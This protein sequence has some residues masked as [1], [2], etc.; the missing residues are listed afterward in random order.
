MLGVDAVVTQDQVYEILDYSY[1]TKQ[2]FTEASGWNAV[3]RD[4]EG[5]IVTLDQFKCHAAALVRQGRLIQY[6]SE[7]TNT[8]RLAS[9]GGRAGRT[10]AMRRICDRIREQLTIEPRTV[11]DLAGRGRNEQPIRTALQILIALGLVTSRSAKT[12]WIFEWNHEQEKALRDLRGSIDEV[13]TL[14]R[15]IKD[16]EASIANSARTDK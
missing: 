4:P 12:P 2:S 10:N 1:G 9:P 11:K 6:N 5:A 14:Q 7:S 13:R 3:Q 15:R 8:Y 16:A